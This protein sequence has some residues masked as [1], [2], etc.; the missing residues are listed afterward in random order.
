MKT[1]KDLVEAIGA[2]EDEKGTFKIGKFEISQNRIGE[3]IDFC[4][5]DK[6][7]MW[8]DKSDIIGATPLSDIPTTIVSSLFEKKEIVKEEEQPKESDSDFISRMNDEMAF[9]KKENI[10]LEIAL[11]TFREIYQPQ[12]TTSISYK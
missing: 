5:D 10:E 6:I 7:V 8:I 3:D 12:N 9:L 1:I 2:T 4:V 11:K